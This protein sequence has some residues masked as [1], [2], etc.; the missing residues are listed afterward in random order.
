MKIAMFT[1]TYIPQINGVATSVHIFIKY[2]E[3]RGHE[4]YVVAPAGPDD[5]VNVLKVKGLTWPT[6]TQHKLAIAFSGRLRNFIKERKIE[7]L[8][9]H[10][11]FVLGFR[12]LKMQKEFSIPHVHTYHTL[13][14]EYRHYIP[15]PFTPSKKMVADFSAWFCNM[16]NSVIAPTEEIKKELLSYGVRRRIHVIPTGIDTETFSKP[17]RDIRKMLNL[18]GKKVLLYVGRLAKEKNVFFLLE[19]MKRMEKGVLLLMVGDGPERERLEKKA[20]EERLNIIF[21]GRVPREEL[22]DYYHA[23]DVFVFSSLTETQGLVVLE[24]LSSGTPV[25]AIARKGIKNVLEDGRGALLIGEENV[26]VFAEKVKMLLQDEKLLERM[27][28]EGKKY[29]RERWAMDVMAEKLEKVYREAIEEGKIEVSIP[30]INMRRFIERMRFFK[31]VLEA[32][33]DLIWWR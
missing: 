15:K 24:S 12:A 16:V 6:E 29:V 22:V 7:I 31:E 30:V 19:V 4:V 9:S 20:R 23:A 5:D 21:T 33:E 10:D 17:K 27:R 26:D 1:D 11:P 28:E 8:H 18:K 32:F 25:V 13:L 2:L 3:K 14:V